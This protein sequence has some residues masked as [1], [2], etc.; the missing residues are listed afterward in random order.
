MRRSTVHLRGCT[1]CPGAGR[2]TDWFTSTQE[3]SSSFRTK[4]CSVHAKR[5]RFAG[6][7]LLHFVPKPEPVTIDQLPQELSTVHAKRIQFLDPCALRSE[8]G[9]GSGRLPGIHVRL[10]GA[11][12]L[13]CRRSMLHLPGDS[14]K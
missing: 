6:A 3:L 10:P 1:K 4:R 5:I 7:A 12:G 11:Q 13:W 2:R 9:T 8:A 14:R